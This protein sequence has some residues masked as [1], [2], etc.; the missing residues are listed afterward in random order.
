MVYLVVRE[1]ANTVKPTAIISGCTSSEMGCGTE[2][3]T[4]DKWKSILGHTTRYCQ[5]RNMIAAYPWELDL[6]SPG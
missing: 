4:A 1:S 3:G 2:S 5:V 6:H